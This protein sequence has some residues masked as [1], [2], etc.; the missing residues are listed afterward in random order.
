VKGQSI[1]FRKNHI[2]PQDW[3]DILSTNMEHS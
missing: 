1:M 2:Q 3:L